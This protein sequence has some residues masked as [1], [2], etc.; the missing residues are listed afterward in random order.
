MQEAPTTALLVRQ[1][2]SSLADVLEKSLGAAGV[3]TTVVATPYEAILEADRS[4]HG[5]RFLILGVDHFGRDQYR[6]VPMARREWPDTTVVAYHSPGFGY[7]GRLAELV[8]ADMVLTGLDGV[9]SLLEGLAPPEAG[10][11]SEPVQPGPAAREPAAPEPPAPESPAPEPPAPESP[12]PEPPATKTAA[13]E[14]AADTSSVAQ[15]AEEDAASDTPS[16]KKARQTRQAEPAPE[17]PPEPAEQ[18]E[19]AATDQASLPSVEL[20]DEELR[21]LLAEDEDKEGAS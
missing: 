21:L 9:S 13:P 20:S 18:A 7:K 16:P 10:P 2:G 19:P 6:L 14:S 11:R 15:R 3:R 1:P 5:Y 17:E 4:P 8:G 12:A